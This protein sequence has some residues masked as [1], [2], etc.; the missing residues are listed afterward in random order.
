MSKSID[1]RSE[2]SNLAGTEYFAL[3]G[4]SRPAEH[5]CFN[6]YIYSYYS[7]LSFSF[8]LHPES[9]A[10][11]YWNDLHD[12]VFFSPWNQVQEVHEPNLPGHGG[13]G[14][15]FE[16]RIAMQAAYPPFCL[17]CCWLGQFVKATSGDLGHPG[18]DVQPNFKKK[19]LK[20]DIGHVA[21]A[22]PWSHAVWTGG[23]PP[24]QFSSEDSLLHRCGRVDG[25]TLDSMVFDQP[26]AMIVIPVRSNDQGWLGVRVSCDSGQIRLYERSVANISG[27]NMSN[28]WSHEHGFP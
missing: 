18:W 23:R 13:Q 3:S 7:N 16:E 21:P 17:I 14:Q 2:L 15:L 26:W 10:E 20:G 19:K 8:F 1:A 6:I 25:V 9:H 5:E 12:N 24:S 11:S 4:S 27:G 22:S 28:V